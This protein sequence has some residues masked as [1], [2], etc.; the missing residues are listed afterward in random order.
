[1]RVD[2]MRLGF[3][4]IIVAALT[5]PFSA[6]WLTQPTPGIPRTA[7]GKP[8]LGAPAPR[9]SDG[10]PDFSGVWMRASRTV[11]AELRPVQPSVEALV[12]Q[13][14]E[15]F[16]DG[17]M[18]ALCLPLGP[19][20]ITARGFDPNIAGMTKVVQTPGLIL[21]LNPDL[22]YRQIFLDGRPLETDPNPSWMGY[23]VGRWEG[24]TLVVESVG[25][26]DRTWLDGGY[27][28]TE[29]LRTVERYRRPD[30]G[31]LEL[32]V[33]LHDPGLYA[34]PW[35]AAISAQLQ[36]DTELLEYVC[37]ENTRPREHWV[38]KLSDARRSEVS[39]APA[40][41]A[42]YVGTYVEQKPFYLGPTNPR[43]FEIT[44]AGGALFVEGATGA[45][46]RLVAQSEVL[47]VNGG[48]GLA[49]VKERQEAPTHLLDTHVSGDYRFERTK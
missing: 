38:G 18:T 20:Y 36:A 13:R 27:P 16:L 2:G 4:L 23:S 33:T 40:I 15:D 39:I 17:D 14:R 25:F 28:H 43:T 5:R 9:T 48:L 49:F 24:D 34:A 1:M 31:R 8:N 6:Q 30:L 7:N 19:R 12:R 35:T 46:T 3:L 32:D 44:F 42:K 37:A 41:L 22:T 11:A 10:R 26:N 21:I 47:F 29:A 45:K